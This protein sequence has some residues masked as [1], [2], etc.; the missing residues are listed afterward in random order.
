[1]LPKTQAKLPQPVDPVA[2][3]K[4]PLFD[5]VDEAFF[6]SEAALH[7]VEA[8]DDFRDLDDTA[9]RRLSRKRSWRAGDDK[10]KKK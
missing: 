8:V 7:K 9:K 2:P 1:M 3:H 6:A 10:T 5:D 4:E